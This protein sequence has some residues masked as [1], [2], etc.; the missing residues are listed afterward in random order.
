MTQ[1]ENPFLQPPGTPPVHEATP[2]EVVETNL[3][4]EE[5]P[6]PPF[7]QSVE[8]RAVHS[9]TGLMTLPQ[10]GDVFENPQTGERQVV[11]GVRKDSGE[12]M[13]MFT[14]EL[15]PGVRREPGKAMRQLP[16]QNFDIQRKVGE[17][18]EFHS[19]EYNDIFN[20]CADVFEAVN[21]AYQSQGE[22]PSP[23][24]K[25]FMDRIGELAKTVSQIDDI[26][27][28]IGN[29]ADEKGVVER[30]RELIE[31]LKGV[32]AEFPEELV[33]PYPILQRVQ[34]EMERREIKEQD[35]HDIEVHRSKVKKSK[36]SFKETED[37]Q[38]GKGSNRG[39]KSRQLGGAKD[40]ARSEHEVRSGMQPDT[41]VEKNPSGGR[42]FRG[43][44]RNQ[45][46]LDLEVQGARKLTDR[47]VW[48]EFQKYRGARYSAER[49]WRDR[50]NTLQQRIEEV[51]KQQE[52]ITRMAEL[53]SRLRKTREWG[54]TM[55]RL[56]PEVQDIALKDSGDLVAR[57]LDLM[58]RNKEAVLAKPVDFRKDAEELRFLYDYFF[59]YLA[60]LQVG[61]RVIASKFVEPQRR[62]SQVGSKVQEITGS[63][64][65][66]EVVAQEFALARVVDR[67]L[68]EQWYQIAEPV[69][70]EV[71]NGLRQLV[72]QKDVD[73]AEAQALLTQHGIPEG[74]QMTIIAGGLAQGFNDAV[75]QVLKSGDLPTDAETIDGITQ[76][77]LN[78]PTK[79][80]L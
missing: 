48:Q 72:A 4:Q 56:G 50:R 75:A 37:G 31:R 51:R 20:D 47:E 21:R 34:T 38:G 13:I 70:I 60:A 53:I 52:D 36:K 24:S 9:R 8:G 18:A 23:E 39:R 61:E 73:V 68:G 1:P 14:P 69:Q 11:E 17:F 78:E 71:I 3:A 40:N 57:D 66:A 79:K 55:W 65:E 10:K 46:V 54:R 45:E 22:N 26:W 58:L 27:E 28:I 64:T 62:K 6:K 30:K 42:E 16:L 19:I 32:V 29:Q 41:R 15:E 33:K 5:A 49:W 67:S 25:E 43:R 35:E 2:S 12:T 74:E 59:R 76:S 77:I 44:Q 80:I 7:S 63:Q